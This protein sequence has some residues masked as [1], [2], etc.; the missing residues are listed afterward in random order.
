MKDIQS[1]M[2][3]GKGVSSIDL[4][5][6]GRWLI[7]SGSVV[8]MLPKSEEIKLTFGKKFSKTTLNLFLFNDLLIVAKPKKYVLY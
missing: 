8:H 2:E 6:P 1:K 5:T 3:F 7:R 4:K